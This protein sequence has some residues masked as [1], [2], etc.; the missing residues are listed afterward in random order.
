MLL[1]LIIR[2]SLYILNQVRSQSEDLEVEV[3]HPQSHSP[4][5]PHTCVLQSPSCGSARKG[6]LG[7]EEQGPG[8]EISLSESAWHLSPSSLCAWGDCLAYQV[9]Q[10]M[11][12]SG[13]YTYVFTYFE[14]ASNIMYVIEYNCRCIV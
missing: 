10:N 8:W 9:K 7:L 6:A 4:I 1:K 5:C 13:K 3:L 14:I 12:F 11:E 2:Q